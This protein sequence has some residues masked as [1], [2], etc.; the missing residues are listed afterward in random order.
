[1]S[2]ALMWRAEA[3]A[4]MSRIFSRGS[5]T[6]RPALRRSLLSLVE[7]GFRRCDMLCQSGM[8][9]PIINHLTAA[10]HFDENIS[11]GSLGNGL[12]RARIGMRLPH[13][14]SAGQFLG[15]DG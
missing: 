7:S 14:Y 10:H 11:T 12:G 1:M 4:R 8:M 2:S 13:Q 5:V 3:S 9:G 15:P 6:F